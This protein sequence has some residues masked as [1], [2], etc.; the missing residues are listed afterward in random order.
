MDEKVKVKIKIRLDEDGFLGREC[1]ECKAYFKVKP[2][3]GLSI[4]YH[5]CPYCGHQ[6]QNDKFFTED[7]IEYVKSVAIREVVGP[8][9]DD[10][11]RSLRDLEQS[12]SG[13]LIQIK[14]ETSGDLFKIKHYQEKILETNV[15]CDS[16]GLNFSIYGVFSNCPDCGRLN[17]KV[18]FDKSIEVLKK[19]L[20]LSADNEL[21]ILVRE[22]FLRDS[23]VGAV[24]SFDSLGKALKNKHKNIFPN[25]PKNLFQNFIELDNALVN[26]FKKGIKELLSKEDYEFLFK[27]FQVRH[28]YEHTAGVI[29]DDF[30]AKLPVFSLEKGR[31]YKLE[32]FEINDFLDKLSLLVNNIYTEVE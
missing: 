26:A 9:F 31:K 27:M 7:Q 5:I 14:V 3:T 29:D 8:V 24:S 12:T 23:L 6:G 18:I 11:N 16:C 30:I 19:K 22:D 21:D 32:R 10:L 2:G 13:G 17:A 28:I 15:C 4:H 1:P 20:E 25:K